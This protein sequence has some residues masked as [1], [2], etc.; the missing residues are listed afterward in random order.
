M[1]LPFLDLLSR[2]GRHGR[3]V[4]KSRTTS[5]LLAGGVAGVLAFTL[6]PAQS[7]SLAAGKPEAFDQGRGCTI[8]GTTAGDVLKGTDGDDVICGGGGGDTIKA[9]AG[10]DIIYG[11]DGGDTI[12]GG[13]GDDV[14]YGG[15]GGDTIR[16]EDGADQIEA[17]DGGDTVHAGPGDD[18]IWGGA[19]GDTL[20]GEDGADWVYGEAGADTVRGGAGDDTI[21]DTGKADT[22]WGDDGSDRIVAGEGADSV[23]GNAGDDLLIGGPGND[24]HYG[25]AGWDRCAG[26][27]GV[28]A[29]Y[30]CEVKLTPADLGGV[31]GDVDGDGMP[32]L[33]EIRAG[34]DPLRRDTDGDGIDDAAEF[35]MGTWPTE[36]DS[37]GDGVGDLDED[38]DGDGLT[39]R[40]EL[41]AGTSGIK[42]D[43]DG[44]G[45]GD[46]D[47]LAAGL[48]PL[49]P[50]SDGDGLSDGVEP[51]VGADPAR[52][53]TDGD[54]IGDGED[55]FTVTLELAEP[56]AR[57]VATGL[58]V[59]LL[60]TR[61][62]PSGD[63]RL[64]ELPG[65]RSPPVEVEA[66]EG[67][68]GVLT[69]W[70]DT[71]GL[72]PADEVALLH[73]DTEEDMLD[74]PAGQVV[75]WAAG[76]VTAEVSEFSPFV[77]VDV[78]EFAAIW[79]A[80]LGLGG[81]VGGF[82][83]E[84]TDVMLVLD[85]SGSMLDNDPGRLRV[86][87]ASLLIDALKDGDRVGV[88]DFDQTA[89][90][91]QP[92]SDDFQAA[93]SAL[94]RV[95]ANGGTNLS[96]PMS[97]ALSRLD[98]IDWKG[99]KRAIVLLTDGVGSYD[100][101]LTQWAKERGIVVYTV[102]LGRATDEALLDEIASQT[103]GKFFL[104]DS[105]DDLVGI[106]R[107]EIAGEVDTDGDGLA[108]AAES[109]GMR[110]STGR[111]YLTDPDDPDSDGDGLEDGAEMGYTPSRGHAFGR[112]TAYQVKS[113]PRR[114]D[115]D[116]DG[117]GDWIEVADYLFP[118]DADNDHD[119]AT[120][121]EEWDAGS[122]ELYWNTDGDDLDDKQ[123]IDLFNSDESRDPTVAEVVYDNW[124]IADMVLRG[125]V[126][127]DI[128]ADPEDWKF[129]SCT[130]WPYIAGVIVGSIAF[131]TPADLRD[132][133]ANILKG[134]VGMTAWSMAAFLPAIGDSAKAMKQVSDAL[135]E[136]AD[137]I[138]KRK[139]V[140]TG[141]IDPVDIARVI[142][143]RAGGWLPK[144]LAIKM[145]DTIGD[146]AI[147]RSLE[148]YGAKGLDEDLVLRMARRGF[149]PQHIEEM[150][151]TALEL[152]HAPKRGYRL[153]SE[154]RN[155]YV[156][157]EVVPDGQKTERAITT[158][159]AEYFKDGNRV[160]DRRLLDVEER[161]PTKPA[162]ELKRGKVTLDSG[163]NEMQMRVDGAF[164]RAREAG[165]PG[166]AAKDV[167][168]NGIIR[169]FFPDQKR[170][171]IVGPD[172]KVLAMLKEEGLDYIVYL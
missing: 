71:A 11:D 67:V 44:D 146:G 139:G 58:A 9:G 100:K 137:V 142:G 160:Q 4:M 69:V 41:A 77:V 63:L 26:G 2:S 145:L 10:N 121:G 144:P 36:A 82:T 85:S 87:A 22:L 51:R 152:R 75:D 97:L 42:A 57:L 56:T 30:S 7:P 89:R 140:P 70:F 28:N 78:A 147:T 43:T 19:G 126:C 107:D 66:P 125:A 53:D 20:W 118:W 156:L 5:A 104:A 31:D 132:L 96:A 15:A 98:S 6:M 130:G 159:P 169:M 135:E 59:G 166:F 134:D 127:G 17:G 33:A 91:L 55:T 150:L 148:K 124:Q 110:T 128:E 172:P 54:G 161:D 13:P 163:C 171:G 168:F 154:W 123:E 34:S 93:K 153:E 24:S 32:D 65:Q 50:D 131:V 117:V 64:T 25:D 141:S 99:S 52:F 164:R 165:E 151:G 49:N 109:G 129:C 103:G 73:Y 88:V 122:T 12:Y 80:E 94:A 120:G 155:E 92:L 113:D 86:T 138:R 136:V 60:E 72:T 111:V 18:V 119:G 48:D 21:I 14:I 68:T 116:Y 35:D 23:K 45:V 81:S 16:G 114:Q 162:Y 112:G 3:P 143:T 101:V 83:R 74:V 39:S 79:K 62:V 40:E 61:M 167:E 1:N 170:G 90:L 106:F 37:D 76:T 108:D 29:Y 84:P 133:G 47:E 157:K 8:F 158:P 46:G 115:T 102:G 95:R 27:T 38:V 149:I 105:A